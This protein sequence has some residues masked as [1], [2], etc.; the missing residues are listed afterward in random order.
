[1]NNIND[2]ES[3]RIEQTLSAL[4][5]FFYDI[6]FFF[7]ELQDIENIETWL[8]TWMKFCPTC[9]ANYSNYFLTQMKWH[10]LY[11]PTHNRILL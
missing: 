3:N 7:H 2:N 1:M 8:T 9:K 4:H 5:L 10:V 6:F 11:L